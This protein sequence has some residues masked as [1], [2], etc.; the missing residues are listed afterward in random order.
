MLDNNSI[1]A[2]IL[3]VKVSRIVTVTGIRAEG[4]GRYKLAITP[5][6]NHTA[7]K[8]TSEDVGKL[9]IHAERQGVGIQIYDDF[10]RNAGAISKFTEIHFVGYVVVWRA[11]T[12]NPYA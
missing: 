6:L 8:L 11:N 10:F 2:T 4:L 1:K 12:G 7:F 5:E 9:Y 3:H